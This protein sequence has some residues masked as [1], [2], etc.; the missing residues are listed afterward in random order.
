MSIRKNNNKKDN[1]FMNLA[2][3]QAEKNLGNTKENPSVGCVIVKDNHIL[4]AG[5]TSINGRP[6]AEYNAINSAKSNIK[7]SILYST[8]EPCSNY[9]KTPPCVNLIIKNKIKKVFF[10]T[11]D[12]DPRSY[13]KSKT[14]LSKKKISTDNQILNSRGNI[15][16]N[17]YIRYKK[18][19][20]PFVTAKIAVSKD[21]YTKDNR[22][23]WITNKY[24]R[25]R[26]HLLRSSHDCLIT[27][28][29]TIIKDNPL[30]DCRI[31]GMEKRS[32]S[33][34]VLDKYL[35]IPL[36]SRLIKNSN[37]RNIYI[38]FNKINKNKIKN[39]KKLKIKLIKMPLNYNNNFDLEN[40]LI[41]I[42]KLGFSR[43]FI[44]CGLKLLGNFINK[45]LINN[46]YL[47]ISDKKL[48]KNG[49]KS[50]NK[51][52]KIIS[53]H[54]KTEEKVNLLGERLIKYRLN[55]V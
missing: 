14:L 52:M 37:K 24:S 35:K 3:M 26:V 17:S 43:I 42:K 19:Y 6:H 34:I 27:S 41:R 39:L 30:L 7:N 2:F 46:L 13:N 8:L 25:G 18:N 31:E 45:N 53:K 5:S 11:L 55:N 1:F 51:Y 10:S 47:F 40:I 4:S 20:L 50:I 44:E 54:N 28:L 48:K 15:F 12:P 23:K 29:N 22:N 38:F 21:M 9:G 33:I 49:S 16:Y 36:N 32:P